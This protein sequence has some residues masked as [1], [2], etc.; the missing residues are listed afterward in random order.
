MRLKKF[1]HVF[2]AACTL[3][4]LASVIS[5]TPVAAA[6]SY[7]NITFNPTTGAPGQTITV[8]GSV[9]GASTTIGYILFNSNSISA[10]QGNFYV[11]GS[12]FSGSFTVPAGTIPGTYNIY[13]TTT[14]ALDDMGLH[15]LP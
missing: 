9:A 3:G 8:S 13:F 1:F 6:V 4:L 7:T 15:F 5:F 10:S 11:S 2:L 12:S 14:G